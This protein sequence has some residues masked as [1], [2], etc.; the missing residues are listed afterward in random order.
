V[1]IKKDALVSI[2]MILSD[3]HGNVIEENEEEIIYL[4]GGYGHI[5]KK[6]EEELEGK[7]VGNEFDVKLSASEAF[8]EFRE[9]LILRE[10]LS[11]M[12]IDVAVGMELDGEEE[13][14]IYQVIEMDETHAILDG[15][16]PYAGV[17][18]IATGEVMEIEYLSTEAIAKILEDDHHH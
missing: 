10:P 11:E 17:A 4:H 8:G 16:H 6:L 1:N 14:V 2:K 9:D 3:E 13:G 5:F 12:P 15:N 18:M 7:E